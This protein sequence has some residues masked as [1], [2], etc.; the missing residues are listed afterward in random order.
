MEGWILC[1]C[2][3]PKK[4]TY[5]CRCEWRCHYKSHQNIVTSLVSSQNKITNKIQLYKCDLRHDKIDMQHIP[6]NVN[7]LVLDPRL[8]INCAH[9]DTDVTDEASRISRASILSVGLRV[10]MKYLKYIICM[11][12]SE[13]KHRKILMTP[14][15]FQS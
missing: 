11:C 13:G 15:I 10:R 4:A 1:L 14:V 8:G 2:T 6:M 7:F 3:Q 12:L 5:I 9:T